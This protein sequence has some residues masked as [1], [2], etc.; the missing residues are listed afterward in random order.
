MEEYFC[1]AMGDVEGYVGDGDSTVVNIAQNSV[2][3][4]IYFDGR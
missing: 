1:V 4:L 2:L 3:K